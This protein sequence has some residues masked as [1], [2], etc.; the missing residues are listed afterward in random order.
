[1]KKISVIIPTYKP[2]VYIS[3]CLDSL[4]R[5]TIDKS[6]YEIIIVLNGIKTPYYDQL[7]DMIK[8]YANDIR[9][10]Y[11]ECNGVSNARNIGMQHSTGE[12]IA[13]IDDDDWVTPDYLEA[14]LTKADE[15]SIVASNVIEVDDETKV[16]STSYNLTKAFLNCYQQENISFFNGR[17]FL[18]PVWA[19]L[20]HRNIIGNKKFPTSFALGEDSLFMFAISAN[21]KHIK[22]TEKNTIYYLRKR[23]NSA[24]HRHYSYGHRVKVAMKTCWNYLV[25][26]F[27]GFGRYNFLL[28]LTRIAATLKK[29]FTKRYE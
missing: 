19:K 28:F 21:I 7:Q 25:I 13:F 20:I 3:D 15:T 5:Q 4:C 12:Y 1:M 17:K 29:L 18:S 26:F 24:S 8:K 14:L 2:D 6:L 16:E 9:I 27:K 10:I 23:A 22:F 11:S